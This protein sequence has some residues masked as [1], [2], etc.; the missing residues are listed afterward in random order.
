[1]HFVSLLV[2]WLLVAL[3]S[4]SA[5]QPKPGTPPA[6]SPATS[7][8]KWQSDFE[9]AR[10]VAVAAKLHLLLAF[11][12]ADSAG[13]CAK[14]DAEVL[15]VPE[16]LNEVSKNY[17]LVRI[18]LP[19]DESQVPAALRQQNAKLRIKYPSDRMPAIWLCDSY[20]RS[21][22]EGTGYLPATP[23]AMLAW[24]EDRRQ[25]SIAAT[26]AL[27]KASTC[28]G[29][30]RAQALADGLQTLDDAIV[31]ANY[32][33]E[34]MEI[35]QLDASGAAGLK[36][37]FDPIARDAAARPM[38]VRM[39]TELQAL[40]EQKQWDEL[41]ARVEKELGAHPG[42][43]WAE[44]Y[45]SFLKGTCRLEG[46]QDCAGALSLFESALKLAPRSE[47]APEVDRMRQVAA[48]AVE[49]QKAAERKAAEEA[50]R[51]KK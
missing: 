26:A 37:R 32:H 46:R 25:A 17:L 22:A 47:L 39:Q 15:G 44:Q 45:L 12:T 27:Q 23:K 35:I 36:T 33:K 1:M 7:D 42:E 38:L 34:L 10:Q 48:A 31:A 6:G 16:F 51:R 18:D 29:I 20:G 24:V 40:R 50:K 19:A 4:A 21:Y 30:E 49:Q 41:E 13:L 3:G 2:F 9:A 5:Q 8:V 43:R 11:M 28:R 14:L